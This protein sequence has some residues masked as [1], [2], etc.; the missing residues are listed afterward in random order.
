MASVDDVVQ[1]LFDPS[2]VVELD[3]IICRV[4]RIAYVVALG[5]LPSDVLHNGEQSVLPLGLTLA[6]LFEDP[7][8]E[9]LRD[10]AVLDG[11]QVL[12]VNALVL[13]DQLALVDKSLEADDQHI[14]QLLEQ[15][16]FLCFNC[17]LLV[18]VTLHIL[19]GEIVVD[20]VFNR[21]LVVPDVKG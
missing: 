3:P 15:L 9:V 18:L 21:A 7:E 5:C 1:I 11:E 10:L 16:L 14:G 2:F 6:L 4:Q 17:T 20:A 13:L 12:E 8:L 19:H